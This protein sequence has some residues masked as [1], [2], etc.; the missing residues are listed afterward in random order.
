MS[1]I[2]LDTGSPRRFRRRAVLLVAATACAAAA[3]LVGVTLSE[4]G[5][6]TAWAAALVRVAETA[7]RLLV[8]APGWSVT[9]ADEFGVGRGEMTFAGGEQRLD[10]QWERGADL[11]AKLG[12]AGSGA[13]SL[14]TTTVEGTEAQ[15][16]RYSGGND[17]VAAWS[18][19]GY[20]LQARGIAA[21]L[22]TF[23]AL[24][25]T[26]HDVDVDTWLSAM[27]ESVVRPEGRSKV[28]LDML[29]GVP[30]PPGFDV[31]SM[32]HVRAGT[33]LDRYQLGAKVAS[34]VACAWLD[35]WVAARHSGDDRGV[36][37]A[38]G[39][40]ATS[41][42]WRV[43]HDMQAEGAYPTVLWQYADAAA[44]NAPIAAGKNLSVEESYG[45]ALGCGVV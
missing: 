2:A 14:G 3:A 16:Y 31:A 35:R 4:R 25:R 38:V 10:V 39:A 22:A 7:P 18:Q 40:L 15:L 45:D 19:D 27:P 5:G 44:S 36:R 1:E 17:F 23:T 11:G 32:Q 29:D 12:E 8:D 26:L 28:V 20:G 33:V 34:G 24:V 21:D 13:E 42:D 37:Q 30:L 43:L 9:R 6:G 41:H